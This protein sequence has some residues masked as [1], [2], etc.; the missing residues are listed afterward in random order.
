MV[1]ENYLLLNN[2]SSV[3][4]IIANTNLLKNIRKSSKSIVMHCNTGTIKTDLKGKLDEM[5]VHHNPKA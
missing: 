5:M 4:Q 1:I 2:K 3:N